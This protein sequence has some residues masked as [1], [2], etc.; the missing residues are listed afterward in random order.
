MPKTYTVLDKLVEICERNSVSIKAYEE[1]KTLIITCDPRAGYSVFNP[2]KEVFVGGSG[3][4]SD[5]APNRGGAGGSS[6]HL[7]QCAQCKNYYTPGL[8]HNCPA[9]GGGN[10]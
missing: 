4:N 3:G 6:G 8:Y 2:L 7:V 10:G 9:M 5:T 1:L